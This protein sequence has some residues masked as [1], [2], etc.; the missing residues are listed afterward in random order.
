ME[1]AQHSIFVLWIDD[2]EDPEFI[3]YRLNPNGIEVHQEFC[4]EDGIAWL[5][6]KENHAKC[7]AVILD[8]KCKI[9]RTDT[10]DSDEA[11][12]N[13]AFQ[14]YGMCEN[15]GSKFIPWFVFTAGTG[16]KPELLEVGIP[17]RKWT[18]TEKK[19]YSKGS[20]RAKLVEHIKEL[21]KDADNVIIRSK[22][23]G[24]CDICNDGE[25]LRF[26]KIARTIDVDQNFASTSVFNDMR[27]M[28]AY[29]KTYGKEHGLFTD[30]VDS[31]K[32]ALEQLDN[33]CTIDP[34]LVP[35]YIVTNY[36][37]LIDTVNNGSHSDD[38]NVE[39]KT[40]AV[41]KDVMS[42]KAPYLSRLA[43]LQ[44]ITIFEWLKQLPQQKDEISELK[45]KLQMVLFDKVRYYEEH[46]GE[47]RY[48]KGIP[49]VGQCMLKLKEGQKIAEFTQVKLKHVV[50]NRD[51][52]FKKT[53]EFFA[54]F[55]VI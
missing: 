55:D 19:Y 41:D 29:T 42:A 39:E 8:V 12:Q 40:L 15:N 32:K 5:S 27:K 31:V 13:Y 2:K 24:I 47:L 26:L 21:T 38:E 23:A 43:F 20:D 37:S 33:I 16:Y 10:N 25:Q 4:Y 3:K 36:E 22:Y 46:I 50:I 45:A 17:K 52:K 6:N 14:V 7:D 18:L 49:H 11:F 28:L 51:P 54:L 53:Y 9:K 34:E 1:K 35:K 48:D 30:D 44:L